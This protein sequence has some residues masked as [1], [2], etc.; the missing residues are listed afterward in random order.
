M[1]KDAN[2]TRARMTALHAAADDASPATGAVT[3][4]TIVT[5]GRTRRS[6]G[7]PRARRENSGAIRARASI[8]RGSATN[9]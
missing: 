6:A 1:Q 4:L 9:R 8:P 5:V 3:G 2:G 7:K